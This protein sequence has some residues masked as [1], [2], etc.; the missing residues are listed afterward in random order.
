[1]KKSKLI[2]SL[3]ITTTLLL[4]PFTVNLESITNSTKNN[5]TSFIT[6][7]EGDAA[8]IPWLQKLIWPIAKAGFKYGSNYYYNVTP[9]VTYGAYG[10]TI[11]PGSI[12]FNSSTSGAGTHFDFQVAS[13]SHDIVMYADAPWYQLFTGKISVMLENPYR[14]YV[15]NN[16]VNPTQWQTYDPGPTG[17]YRAIWIQN[18]KE[19]WTPYLVYRHNRGYI[20]QE[21]IPNSQNEL[22]KSTTALATSNK[23]GNLNEHL[24]TVEKYGNIVSPSNNHKKAKENKVQSFTTLT[25]EELDQQFYDSELQVHVYGLKDYNAGDVIF[26][27]DTIRA[28]KFD[29]ERKNTVFTV[30]DENIQ[31]DLHFAGDITK[32]YEVGQTLE[33]KFNVEYLIEDNSELTIIDYFKYALDN[34]NK[35]PKIN[36]YIVK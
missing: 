4:S 15:I 9:S 27:K 29:D 24:I 32:K 18:S 33:L 6:K 8:I 2:I 19:T 31:H 22:F 21:T 11:T 23:N 10:D 14:N 17:S 5:D 12:S 13:S 25:A 26:L 28:I 30:G 16:S 20:A 3:S 36:K 7:N 35:A 1:M 34:N